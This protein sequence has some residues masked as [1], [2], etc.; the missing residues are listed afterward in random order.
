MLVLTRRAGQAL[1]ID[2]RTRVKIESVV[3]NMVKLA[4][5]APKEVIILRNELVDGKKERKGPPCKD[6]SLEK[7]SGDSSS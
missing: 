4:I 2:G 5:D 6:M 1:I 3:G 7:A